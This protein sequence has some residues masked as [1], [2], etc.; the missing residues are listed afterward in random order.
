MPESLDVGPIVLQK[1]LVSSREVRTGLSS[2]VRT[3][4]GSTSLTA[5]KRAQ[6]ESAVSEP[7]KSYGMQG[8]STLR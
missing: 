1:S 7:L 3:P 2:A 4:L 6:S 8:R 5:W